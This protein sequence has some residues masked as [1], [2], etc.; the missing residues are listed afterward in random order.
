MNIIDDDNYNYNQ[1]VPVVLILQDSV[2]ATMLMELATPW[3]LTLV[4]VT[5]ARETVTH[6]FVVESE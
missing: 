4:L 2:V 6:F 5:L 1:I 3:M